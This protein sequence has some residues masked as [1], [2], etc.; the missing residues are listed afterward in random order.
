MQRAQVAGPRCGEACVLMPHMPHRT[1]EGR[2]ARAQR[3]H[4]F[5]A[6]TIVGNHHH[7]IGGALRRQRAQHGE[8]GVGTVVGE[9]DEPDF[10]GGEDR[11]AATPRCDSHSL[12]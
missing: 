6:R 11:P 12:T 8:Q 9:N 10:H 4:V 5:G 7:G 2:Q 1:G 3:R